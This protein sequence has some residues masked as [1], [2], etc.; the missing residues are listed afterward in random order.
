[1][2]SS[3]P[4]NTKTQSDSERVA[5]AYFTFPLA[6][7]YS[8]WGGE[9]EGQRVLD[10]FH[11]GYTVEAQKY[12]Q[13][14]TNDAE[15]STIVN[16]NGTETPADAWK[17]WGDAAS[18]VQSAATSVASGVI[19][20]A[21]DILGVAP[22]YQTFKT[23]AGYVADKFTSEVPTLEERVENGVELVQ[24]VRREN[25]NHH[26]MLTGYSLGGLVAERVAADESLDALLFNSAVGK[27]SV[28]ASDAKR[29]VRFRISGD[30]VSK[31]FDDVKQYTFNRKTEAPQGMFAY[32]EKLVADTDRVGLPTDPIQSHW[33]EN[34]ALS[35]TRLHDQLMSDAPTVSTRSPMNVK[36]LVTP[37][38][39]L[40]LIGRLCRPCPKGK[41][42][43][44]C[45]I[46]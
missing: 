41:I 32:W 29:V 4:D 43:C 16:F 2:E 5:D 27:H 17:G 30:V 26:V 28:S 18:P 11:P 6:G 25:P 14:F 10:K 36:P 8:Y 3:V 21:A 45:D 13:V 44:R 37:Q 35:K 15:K 42:F 9:A 39:D 19:D 20:A 34:F 24:R 12:Q 40:F 38:H 23:G 22:Y 1:M 33:L 46:G 31:R 7:V